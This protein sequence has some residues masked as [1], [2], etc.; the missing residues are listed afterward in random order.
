MY[1]SLFDGLSN[2]EAWRL[3]YEVACMCTPG[4]MRALSTTARHSLRGWPAAWDVPT[5]YDIFC[6]MCPIDDRQ[7]HA[8]A[9]VAYHPASLSPVSPV[10][11][12]W[13][14]SRPRAA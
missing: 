2:E 10:G 13:L 11:H 8:D 12:V 5:A 4:D 14:V 1:M 6:H 3:F 7:I 9:P